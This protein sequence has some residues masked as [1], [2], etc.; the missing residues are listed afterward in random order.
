M[1]AAAA[2]AAG[3]LPQARLQRAPNKKRIGCYLAEDVFFAI[4][5]SEAKVHQLAVEYSQ[6]RWQEEGVKTGIFYAERKLK[7][8]LLY[9]ARGRYYHQHARAEGLS[10]T[11]TATYLSHIAAFFADTATQ[12]VYV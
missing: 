3:I 5:L 7:L 9:L 6:W 12:Y 11:A 8:F 2:I 4:R 10:L 1:I